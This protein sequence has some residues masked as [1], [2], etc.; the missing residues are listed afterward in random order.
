ML[1]EAFKTILQ[2]SL[3]GSIIVVFIIMF[4]PLTEKFIGHKF[5]YYVWIPVI[6]TMISVAFPTLIFDSWNVPDSINRFEGVKIIAKQ[7]GHL[8]DAK[9]EIGEKSISW[10]EVCSYLW[11]VG[12]ICFGTGVFLEYSLFK[13]VLLKNSTFLSCHKL[14]YVAMEVRTAS[15]L[16]A[17]VLIGVFSPRLFIPETIT[18]E[19]VIDNILAHELVHL[20]R[21]DLLYKNLAILVRCIH[22]FNPL[23][24]IMVREI[25]KEC[26]ISCDIEATQ[27]MS[28]DEKKEYMRS[29]LYV[30][31]KSISTNI[32]FG[33]GMANK[34]PLLEKRFKEIEKGYKS[35]L[36]FIITGMLFVF[37][38]Q[39]FAVFAVNTAVNITPFT[40]ANQFPLATIVVSAPETV[41]IVEEKVEN[42]LILLPYTKDDNKKEEVL[43]IDESMEVTSAEITEPSQNVSF[44]S[45]EN[46]LKKE[47]RQYI[48][49]EFN[50]DGGDTRIIKGVMPDS[51]GCISVAVLSNAN[52]VVEVSFADSQTGKVL[53]GARSFPVNKSGVCV[54]EDLDKSIKYDVIVKGSLRN[55]WEIESEIIIY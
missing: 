16:K 33:V 40:E 17:P 2:L 26:E 49:T 8:L 41:R 3:M 37:C 15:V 45:I 7:T 28:A 31:E 30:F 19:K 55:N 54:I 38:V 1:L 43:P 24:Y 18:D 12:S 52:E 5:Q 25:E 42:K 34:K 9:T 29:I 53:N 35:K 21:N 32:A 23:T 36:G 6:L 13:K 46:G 10:F 50:Y 47:G 51:K 4:K 11:I 22:W 39:G 27:R 14:K 20:K 44:K 48:K